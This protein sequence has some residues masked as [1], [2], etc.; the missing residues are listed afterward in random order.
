[1]RLENFA[2]MM[3]AYLNLVLRRP[4]LLIIGLVVITIFLAAG[5]RKIEFDS[6]VDSFMPK[7]DEEYLEYMAAKE[8]YGDNDR[9]MLMSVSPES[10]WSAATLTRFD[11]FISD[12][13]EYK[14][15]PPE[16]E[17]DRRRRFEAA[18]NAEEIAFSDLVEAF[19]EDTAFVRFLK[20]HTP[21]DVREKPRLDSGDIHDLRRWLDKDLALKQMEIIDTILSPFTTSDISGENDTLSTYDLVPKDENDRR[22]VPTTPSEIA[23]YRQ[24]LLTNPAFKKLIYATDPETGAVTDFGTI[25]KFTDTQDQEAIVSEI[26]RIAAYHEPLQISPAGVPYVNKKFNDYIKSDLSRSIPLVL[27][28]VT[29]IFY[30]NFRSFRGV[31]LPLATLGMAELWTLGLMGHL[32]YKITSVGGT[33]P[34]LLVAI[35]SSYSIHILNQYYSE[36]KLIA[37]MEKKAGIQSAMNHISITVFLAGLTTFAAFCTL[38]TNKVSALQEWAAFSAI[39]IAA[40][41]FIAVTLIPAALA[42]LPRRYPKGLLGKDKTKKTTLIDAFLK[43]MAKGAIIHYRKVYIVTG[44]VIIISL[45]G[46]TKLQV[47]TEFL[48]YFKEND[49]VRQNVL[50]AGEKFGGGWG[51]SVI[52]DSREPDGVKSPEFLNTVEEIRQWLTADENPDLNIGRTDAF[53]DFIKRMHMAMYDDDPSYF[54]IPESRMDIMDY[55]EIFSGEDEDSDGRVDSFE[56]FVDPLFQKNNILARITRKAAQKIGTTEIK[57]IIDR[58]EKHLENTLPSE[59]SYSI[60]GYPIINMKLAHYVVTGQLQNLFLSLVLV[61][62]VIMI[63]FKKLAAGPLALIDMGVTIII[64][65]GIMGWFGIRLDMVTSIIAAITVGIGIDDTIHYLNTYR[66]YHLETA[67][68]V[69]KTIEKTMR[70]TGKAIMFT[71][72]A[73]IC[74]FF[75][76]VTSN[77]LP[78]VLFSLLLTLTMINTTIGSILLIPAAI[79][80]TGI[81]LEAPGAKGI[82]ENEEENQG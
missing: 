55:L 13:E 61:L 52:I 80:L 72:L 1:M 81:N 78:V 24:R 71:S 70:V 35:G 53:G 6:S 27:L 30:Y 38:L 29:L 79:R 59:Y 73:L 63:L 45:I 4:I 47:D 32:G 42:I 7:H 58:V 23:A 36:F 82:E 31:V 56:P 41:V 14:D 39:G 51:F 11:E 48:H 69:A 43:V 15:A 66:R 76:Q 19:R 54:R 75:V 65:F 40:T 68:D 10:I 20:R 22:I 21:E 57:Y 16:R 12:I 44:I 26:L 17:A 3:N 28:V 74:G 9:F 50:Y 18:V 34:P 46:A 62:F 60:T 37:S 8:I 25:V 67:A 64:N 5:I 33:L 2:S 49:P 77:F